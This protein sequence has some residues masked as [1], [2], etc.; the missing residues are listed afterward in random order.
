MCKTDSVGVPGAN[1]LLTFRGL[2]NSRRLM[3][4]DVGSQTSIICRTP[5][6]RMTKRDKKT[7]GR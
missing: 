6:A 3:G 1:V 7:K 2:L 5:M 4:K